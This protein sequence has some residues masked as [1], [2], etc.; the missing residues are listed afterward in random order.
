MSSRMRQDTHDPTIVNAT[1]GSAVV[2]APTAERPVV[3]WRRS[4]LEGRG[5]QS[6]G[7]VLDVAI[8][9][10]SFRTAADAT[11]AAIATPDVLAVLALLVTIIG[12]LALHGALGV[13][14]GRM[15]RLDATR[16]IFVAVGS[17][18]FV[19]LAVG[20]VLA[21]GGDT[22]GLLALTAAIAAPALSIGRLPMDIARSRARVA[23][24][25]GRAALIV[26]AG[27]I[28]VQ[29]ERRMRERPH[30]GLIPVGFLD[31]DPVPPEGL[32]PRTPVIGTTDDLEEV[33]ERTGAE[34]VIIAFSS[35]P[36]SKVLA[37]VSRCQRLGLEVS[38]VPR[39]FEVI[40]ERQET[41]H[42][43]ALPIVRVRPTDP[44]SAAFA[45]KHTVSRTIAA[46]LLLV[47]GPV[48]LVIAAAVK[49]TSPGPVLFR[50]T[51]VGRDGKVF[52]MYKFRSM[53]EPEEPVE[54][55]RILAPGSAP[56]GVEG[57]DRRTPIGTFM[58]RTS[59]DELPQLLNVL[60]GHMD[61]VGPR[62]ERPDLVELLAPTVRRYDD[63][64][65]VKS[66]MTGWAQINGLR[67]QT[68]LSERIEWDNWYIQNWS[69]WLDFKILVW[70]PLAVLR[71][72]AE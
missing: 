65:R 10:V 49:L 72:P 28:G 31:D 4:A 33:A 63:R 12:R 55:A 66:G 8:L 43:G 42:V 57:V 29:L 68:S 3:Q 37:L 50:Q 38:L 26:G 60:L 5:W 14:P 61:L 6:A 24:L 69:L 15:D 62:P 13:R 20:A 2:V 58:R 9:Y 53:R 64:H 56:G 22:A 19:G 35:T 70:T 18:L 59:L 44:S 48:M 71:T 39:L 40:N 67:G 46:L 27:E 32:Q 21:P 23:G 17:G 11:G 34:H 51:R 52:D 25:S 45:I 30:L 1:P 7:A 41:E 54:V 47:A 16:E 36:D